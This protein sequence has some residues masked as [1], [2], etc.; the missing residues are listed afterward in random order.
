MPRSR[1]FRSLRFRFSLSAACLVTGAAV[2]LSA[3]G[4]GA[5]GPTTQK[6]S[7]A[8]RRGDA[9]FHQ[10]CV[11]CHN[12][13]PG[14]YAPFGPPNLHGVF[15]RKVVTPAQAMSIIRHGKGQMPP[16]AGRLQPEQIRDLIAYLRTQ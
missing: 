10:N 8:A 16:F 6:E 15:Q 5:A 1:N 2:L 3:A 12:K 13:A 7:S 11:I 14:N 4:A 9:L